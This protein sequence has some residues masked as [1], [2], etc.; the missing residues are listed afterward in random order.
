MWSLTFK[1]TTP[2]LKCAPVGVQVHRL[3]SP[4]HQLSMRGASKLF[5]PTQQPPCE[6]PASKKRGEV[7]QK[8]AAKWRNF[9]CAGADRIPIRSTSDENPSPLSRTARWVYDR[10]R[11]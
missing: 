9:G 11:S 7:S 8:W 6:P 4:P 3:V 10:Q 2:T 1:K 5:P